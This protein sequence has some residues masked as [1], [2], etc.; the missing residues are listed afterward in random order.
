MRVTA[1]MEGSTRGAGRSIPEPAPAQG[2]SPPVSTGG[3]DAFSPINN[4]P[5]EN[6]IELVNWFPQ[7]GWVELRKGFLN[8][9]DTDVTDP[10]ESLMA[11]QG[12][13]VASPR[14]FG[15]AGTV[16]YDVTGA[17]GSSSQTGLTNA[18][19]QHVNFATSG[20]HFLW[21]C[22]GDDTPRFWDGAA[23]A[24]A[25]I[26]GVTPE[27]IIQC[28]IYR[29]RIW[30]VLKDS[31]TACY[32][33]LDSVQGAATTLELGGYFMKGGH[34]VA[35]AT[36]SSDV[37][38]GTN[39]YIVF[40]SSF[41]EAAIFLI[42]DPTAPE[43]FA[44]RGTSSLGSPIGRRCFCRMGADLGVIT[45]DGVYPLS[46]IVS[47]D[48]AATASLALTAK[49]MHAMSQ[50][51][52]DFS[53]QFG[54]QLIAYPRGNM[55][56]LNVPNVEGAIQEQFVMNTIT[57]SWCKFT[58]QNAN[59][60][61]TFDNLLY[62]GGNDGIVRLADA[63]AGDEDAIL[64]ADMQCAY[65]YYQARGRNKRWTTLRPLVSKDTSFP[66]DL[67]VGLSID[68]ETNDA[69]DD[70]FTASLSEGAVWD[71]PDTLWD[72][73][74]WPGIVTEAKWVAVSGIGYCASIRMKISVPWDVSLTAPQTLRVNGFDILYD[75]GAFI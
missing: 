35:I 18:R 25:V 31:T 46:K 32:L 55:A 33:P 36:W 64:E 68:F 48:R 11:Y 73:A 62:F 71:D 16:I 67:Q 8:H 75:F 26:T 14:L 22:N 63:A 20:G 9:S 3:W 4:M 70:V 58:G 41:G 74:M 57:G 69:L 17:S 51:A 30:G 44:Y 24:N 7:P 56:I 49:I 61:E 28:A 59:C 52:T 12:E 2:D 45:I 38:Y 42:Y 47:Y 15:A 5:P 53:E 65:N 19:W 10:V 21:I 50:A 23:W 40:I 1:L 43:G 60:W 72:E 66:A 34:L 6:A 27:D 13:T 54:W 29:N 39:E 37:N